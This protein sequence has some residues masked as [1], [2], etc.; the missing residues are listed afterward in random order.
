MVRLDG[1]N[2][3]ERPRGPQ[4]G[5]VGEGKAQRTELVDELGASDAGRD[6]RGQPGVGGRI[7]VARGQRREALVVRVVRN[8]HAIGPDALIP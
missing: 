1:R 2:E 6:V 3:L 8:Q 4:V 5:Q 7:G